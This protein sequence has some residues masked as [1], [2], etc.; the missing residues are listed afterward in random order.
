MLALLRNERLPEQL[1]RRVDQSDKPQ[2]LLLPLALGA[3]GRG[4]ANISSQQQ[5][6]RWYETG[7]M[8]VDEN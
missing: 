6:K 5:S 7:P 8:K 4:S 1:A 2:L 3:N